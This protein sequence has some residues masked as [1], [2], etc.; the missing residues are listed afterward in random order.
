MI[1]VNDRQQELWKLLEASSAE[2]PA[3]IEELA[4]RLQVSPRTIRYDLDSMASAGAVQGWRLCRQTHKGVWAEPVSAGSESKASAYILSR[5]ERYD[6]ILTALI[7]GEHLSIDKLA[8][9]VDVSR[10]TLLGDLKPVTDILERRGLRYSSKRG[11][12]IWVEGDEQAKRD[13]LIHI[14]AKGSYDFRQQDVFCSDS[15]HQAR[16]FHGYTKELPLREVAGFFL[17]TMKKRKA[18][19]NDQS[20]NR[21]ICAILVQI[22][23]IRQGHLVSPDREVDF[24]SSEGERLRDLARELALELAKLESDF[25]EKAE[26]EYLVKELL[27]SRIY[28]FPPSGKQNDSSRE[29]NVESLDMARRFIKYVQIWIGDIYSD[30]D[31]LLYNL[32]MH[33]QPAV[34]RSRFGIVLTNPLLGRIQEEYKELFHVARKAA[35]QLKQDMQVE[36]SDDEIGYLTI[37]LGAAVE[38]RKLQ[39]VKRLNVLLVCGNGVGTANLLSMTLHNRVPFIQIM[40]VVSLYELNDADV[41]AAD[42]VVSIVP[43]TI[44]DKAV[45][46]VSP[47]MSEAEMATIERQ[48]RYFYNKKFTPEQT[49]MSRTQGRAELAESLDAGHILLDAEAGNW[50]AAIRAAG[51]L[52]VDNGDVQPVYVER[53]VDCVRKLGPYIVVCPK[54]AMPHARPEDG[55]N[56]VALSMVRLAKPVSFRGPEKEPVDLLFAF[57][58]IDEKAHIPLLEKL[59][60]LFSR[61]GQLDSLR[62]CDSPAAVRD[63]LREFEKEWSGDGC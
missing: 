52:L 47:I 60:Q 12:G 58:T 46:R 7:D 53:M 15:S 51:R 10:N 25:L 39:Q 6:S 44:R 32:A 36:L 2:N 23:R 13:M 18:V 33:L 28:L 38:R 4:D 11:L 34:D 49:A 24:P 48:M 62:H 17:Q 16:L 41:A 21:M 5:R 61:P 35:E 56:R 27:H 42:M 31:E 57:S 59:W 26:I 37:H 54:V 14:F 43:L 40:K 20:L 9:L 63:K 1:A 45:L 22:R 8:E 50:E 29:M 30:D 19:E 55:V 3:S